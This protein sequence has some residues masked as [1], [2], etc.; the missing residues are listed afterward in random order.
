MEGADLTKLLWA[1]LPALAVLGVW[2][3]IA[4]LDRD[5]QLKVVGGKATVSLFP[6]ILEANGLKIA[7]SRT[8]AVDLAVVEESVSFKAK[9]SDM[10]FT[11]TEGRLNRV[12]GGQV[13]F[14]G[15]LDISQKS[16][17][18]DLDGFKV[19]SSQNVN[20]GLQV[21]A[22]EGDNE[23]V[24][25]DLANP[26]TLFDVQDLKLYVS[27]MDVMVSLECAQRLGKTELAGTLIGTMTVALEVETVD[28]SSIPV[29][30]PAP[31]AAAGPIDV[32]ISDMGSLG[33]L[34][35]VGTYPNGR[36]GLTMSTT[37]CNV[38]T[39]N[40]PWAAPM[41]VNHP[42]IAMNLYRIKDGKFEQVGWSW[43]KHG[44]Y[45][46]NSPGCGTCQHPGGSNPGAQLGPGCSDTYGPGNNGD[47]L[48]LGG[49]DE[50]NPFTG[51][52]TCQNSYFSN[53]QN[54][55]IRRNNGS[56]L[57]AVAHRL[58]VHDA[59][60]GNAGAQYFYEAYY[61]NANETTNKYN[62][63]ASRQASMTWS[64]AAWSIQ[65]SGTP[66]ALGPAINR[67]GDMRSTATPRTEGDVIVAV[68]VTEL[69]GG[70]YNYEYA[71]YNHDLDRQVREFTVPVPETA[72]VQNIGFRDIDKDATNEWVGTFVDGKVQWATGVQGSST[73]NPLKYSSVFN[74]RFDAN[75]PPA[76]GLIKMGLF[77]SGSNPELTAATR[78]PLN[79]QPAATY[80]ISNGALLGGN[81][82]SL[83][84]SDDNRLE[85][86]PLS[87]G[88]RQGSGII[89]SLTAPISTVSNLTFGVESKN[90]VSSTSGGVQTA[91]LWNW[92]TSNWE[93]VDTRATTVND[94]LMVVTVSTNASRFVNSSTR[95]MRFR[96][97][98]SSNAGAIGSRWTMHFDQIG[99]QVN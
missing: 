25:F 72:V 78:A 49:R 48:Y 62:N 6:S 3:G 86:G 99:I 88:T 69:G 81:L 83:A 50:V 60:M 30:P 35:R 5:H 41:Q 7:T 53:Y 84:H 45:A 67:W 42:V 20:D 57:D 76:P 13:R 89:G 33:V 92:T 15:G 10:K 47:R 12:T 8:V 90:S 2:G 22:G 1:S 59:D 19:A 51:V 24:L 31:A 43:L 94:S 98:H 21:R 66:H 29:A 95:E 97:L 82:Q 74:F 44:F 79:L 58:E 73:A 91:E 11:L 17:K 63:I 37:S 65:N 40:I 87:A 70:M 46:T 55:C 36:N 26:R 39:Q 77:K 93:L 14:E 38:G 80:T 56:G 96:V 16:A 27:D 64:G 34:G 75:V 68:K 61:I 52:W 4:Q 71:V 9:Q 32:A 54:D 18:L 23:F 28:G 85:L